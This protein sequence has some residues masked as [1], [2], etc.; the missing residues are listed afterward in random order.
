M[1]VHHAD[2]LHVGVHDRTAD[3]LEA[4]LFEV[5]A[6]CIRLLRCGGQ[7][8]HACNAI[9]NRPPAD[10]APNVLV[11]SAELFLNFEKATGIVDGGCDLEPIADDAFIVQ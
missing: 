4:A 8:F 7:V 9:L 6:Q 10:E 1:I 5:L 11:K 3:E 2:G